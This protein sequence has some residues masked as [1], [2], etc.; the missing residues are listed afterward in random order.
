MASPRGCGVPT[1]R[2]RALLARG[3]PGWG[4]GGMLRQGRQRRAAQ[5]GRLP[6]RARAHQQLPAGRRHRIARV[7]NLATVVIKGGAGALPQ[8]GRQRQAAQLDRPL[9]LVLARVQLLLGRC[10]I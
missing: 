2:A 9:G 1:V 8:R 10:L 6:H 3:G 5:L 7:V 4:V